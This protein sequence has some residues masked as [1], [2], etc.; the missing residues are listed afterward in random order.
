MLADVAAGRRHEPQQYSGDGRKNSRVR[1]REPD[2][3]PENQVDG[4]PAHAEPSQ[5][6][7]RSDAH[8]A[9]QER[10]IVDGSSR[11]SRG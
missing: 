5:R 1:K 10:L 7:D 4:E 3:T 8:E 9:E 2:E 6:R 11:R